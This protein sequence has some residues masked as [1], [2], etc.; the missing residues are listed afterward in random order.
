MLS[1]QSLLKEVMS[2]RKYLSSIES[3]E[4]YFVKQGE[5]IRSIKDTIGYQEIRMY[6]VRER[7]A[8]VTRMSE[9]R[10]DNIADYK[11]LQ[12]E[13]RLAYKFIQFLDN[14]SQ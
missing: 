3:A 8:I 14:L 11:A 10:S 12:A 9:L 13:E 1:P 2:Q 4:E 7:D 6:W 5:A